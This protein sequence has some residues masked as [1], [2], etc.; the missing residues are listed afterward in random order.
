MYR[1]TIKTKY[2]TIVSEREEYNTP[3]LQEIYDQPYVEQI[4]IEN[5]NKVKKLERKLE[6]ERKQ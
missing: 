6:N 3:E 5:L 4:Y 1:I 2:N